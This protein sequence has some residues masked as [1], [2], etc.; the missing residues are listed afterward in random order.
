MRVQDFTLN[1]TETKNRERKAFQRTVSAR[2]IALLAF[3]ELASAGPL[4]GQSP[5]TWTGSGV[6][7]NWMTT[8]NWSPNVPI[9]N[10]YLQFDGTLQLSN[11]NNFP[12]NTSFGR[13]LFGYSMPSDTGPFVLSGN[14][15]TFSTNHVISNYST[16]VQT[17]NLDMASE[18]NAT[19]RAFNNN[20]V[21]AGALSGSGGISVEATFTGV[22]LLSG[23][24]TYSGPT[25]ID[26]GVLRISGG[27]AIPD[28]SSVVIIANN[29][30]IHPP[31]LDINN[32]T[33]TIGSLVSGTSSFE[34]INAVVALGSGTLIIGADNRNQTYKGAISGS[35]ALI[36]IG[37]GVQ[38]LSGTSHYTALT[39]I[40][41]G[42]LQANS[43]V[44]L[45]ENSNLN[46]AG[47]VLQGDGT[48]PVFFTRSTGTG[49]NQVQWTGSGG[50]SANGAKMTV[51]LSGS[52]TTP[53][54]WGSTANFVGNNSALVF[55]SVTANNQ[56]DFQN[57]INLGGSVRTI[58][59]TPGTGGDSALLSGVISG[60]GADGL[61]KTGNGT[62]ILTANNTYSG[63]TQIGGGALQANTGIG[64]PTNS[65]LNLAGGVLQNDGTSPVFF[66]R[67]TGTGVN[68]VQWTG[69]GG[70]SANG[71]K[72][73]VLLS[74]SNTTPLVWGS[75]ANFVGNGSS[76]L[77]GSVS[78]NN[79]IEFQND[80]NLGGSA[81]TINV[82]PGTGG[83]SALLS[84]ILSGNGA[85]G[86]IKTGSG[87]LILTGSNTYSGG[88][89]INNGTLRVNGSVAG[90]VTVA[91]G[92]TL[93]GTGTT[94][95]A[96]V[97]SGGTIAPGD[98]PG[99]L[100]TGSLSLNSG[101]HL[102]MELN[103]VVAGSGY[104][105][106]ITS[107]ALNLNA[108]TGTGSILDL[109]LGYIPAGGDLFFL[110]INGSG[111]PIVGTF[112]GLPEGSSVTLISASIS[113]PY[114]VE[115]T[116]FANFAGN[117]FT[118]GNDLAVRMGP[119]FPEP[120]TLSMLG[121]GLCALAFRFRRQR[122]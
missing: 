91:N 32:T 27:A 16:S 45:P 14:A 84:G 20:M 79:Q 41:A 99:I 86:L 116:Y 119:D 39:Q 87:T 59:V 12:V 65:N 76:L 30:D 2:F 37:S 112:A 73:T 80:I 113:Q 75:T 4:H 36:K 98:S 90:P 53:L 81:R 54:V 6:D 70:F 57:D 96:N 55:G 89:T 78:A 122:M 118:G 31:T 49:A 3:V 94:G 111:G 19:I 74:G 1:F 82:T 58:N 42:A 115:L 100:T 62:L 18:Y 105:R 60:T 107:G 117:S 56:I 35:G 15:I 121:I 8:G 24:N 97:L 68:Q 38:T 46:F 28:A 48:S 17:I 9:S 109:S 85:S 33:E 64:L 52:N 63:T 25:R 67:S 13:I 26:S 22:V 71:A 5:I 72:M 106:I 66:T 110:I 29:N 104:D 50:F 120:G 93:G 10:D 92:G 47:G 103:G 77:F 88:T 69:S 83:D 95:A 23:S 61:I 101:A 11:T 51:L 7:A 108:D 34:Y 114:K 44:G 102:R 40:N 21:L 43:G